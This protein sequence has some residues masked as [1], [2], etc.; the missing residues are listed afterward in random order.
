MFINVRMHLNFHSTSVYQ[1]IHRIIKTQIQNKTPLD[2]IRRIAILSLASSV[3]S[4][5]QSGPTPNTVTVMLHILVFP[6]HLRA[7]DGKVVGKN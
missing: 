2:T 7:S 6:Y 1:L 4:K 3:K 5:R